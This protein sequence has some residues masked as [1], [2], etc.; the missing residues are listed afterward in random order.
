MAIADVFDALTTA[1]PYKEAWSTDQAVE[2]IQ[3]N[4][5]TH[6]DPALVSTFVEALDEVLEIKEKFPDPD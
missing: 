3:Q 6:F 2:L 5:G 1:R 4:A